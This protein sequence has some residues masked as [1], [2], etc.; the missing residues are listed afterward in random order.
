MFSSE[1]HDRVAHAMGKA[2]RDVVRGFRGQ[3]ENPPDLVAYPESVEDVDMVLSFAADAGAAA[4]PFGGGTSVVGGVE[5]R[6]GDGYKGSVSSTCGAWTGCSRWT[7]SR[8][9]RGSRPERWAR[10]WRNSCAS[11]G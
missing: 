11:T 5:P 1:R 3:V 9:R 10:C 7:R 6:V 4:I 2:Y 8:A